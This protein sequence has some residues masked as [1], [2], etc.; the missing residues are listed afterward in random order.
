MTDC[1]RYIT[2]TS[3]NIELQ[4]IGDGESFSFNLNEEDVSIIKYF[5]FTDNVQISEFTLFW[6]N[7]PKGSLVDIDV[8]ESDD[9]IKSRVLIN[10]SLY[11]SN[12]NGQTK[13]MNKPFD[14]DYG[15]RLKV[16]VKN[17]E[18]KKSFEVWGEMGV[19]RGVTVDGTSL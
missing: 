7:A 14:V 12:I 15:H 11:G 18:P 16:I 9:H 4:K 13:K 2:S 8:V 19:L 10:K 5:D 1:G 3:D 6:E 17:G